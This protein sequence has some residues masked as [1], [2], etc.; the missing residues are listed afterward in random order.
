MATIT[1]INIEDIIA[2]K[3]GWKWDN[4]F[5]CLRDKDG[6]CVRWTDSDSVVIQPIEYADGTIVQVNMWGDGTVEF[7]DSDGESLNWTEFDEDVIKRVI[8][9]V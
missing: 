2:R 7:Q 5:S 6:E 4:E 1:E 3:L 8:A 9:A